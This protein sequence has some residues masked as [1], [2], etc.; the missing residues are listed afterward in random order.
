MP[1][2]QPKTRKLISL[3]FALC[4]LEGLAALLFV[5]QTQSMARNAALFGFSTARL[6]MG[7]VILLVALLFAAAA[8]LI[9]FNQRLA[10]RLDE[11]L[12][13]LFPKRE[14]L[15]SALWT[16]AVLF[17]VL[18]YAV[19]FFSTHLSDH[20][21]TSQ[22]V[23]R[24][25]MPLLYW[26]LL[27]LLQSAVLLYAA[28]RDKLRS[29]EAASGWRVAQPLLVTVM[30]LTTAFYLLD[31]LAHIGISFELGFHYYAFMAVLLL[32]AALTVLQDRY[33]DRDWFD[34]VVFYLGGMLIFCTA[35]FIY[36]STAE[37]VNYMHTPSKAYFPDLANAFLNGRL[38]LENPS[39]TMDLTLYNG[40]WYMAFPPLAAILMLPLVARFGPYG[41]S[42]V[43]F[44]LTFAAVNVALVYLI[45]ES[46]SRLGWS[47]LRTRDNLWLV[48]MFALGTIHWYMA[49]T[50]RVW[51]LSR[52]LTVT[53]AALAVLLALRRRSPFWVGLALAVAMAARPNIAFMGVFLLGIAM[54][55]M[56]EAGNL[57]FKRVVGWSLAAVLPMLA[58]VGGLLY[59]NYLRF[60]DW[61]DFGY[62][63]MNVGVNIPVVQQ[64][65]QFHPS[66]IGF[67][68]RYML[69]KLPYI[70][71]DCYGRPVP[72]PQ[73]IS[74]L[75][76][77]PALIYLLRSFKRSWWVAAAWLAVLLEVGL[78]SM[79]TGY[80]W[81]FGYR[82]IMD[83]MLP[84]LALLAIGAG[85]RVSWLMR[86]L[87]LAGVV[88]N[89]CGVL[90][91]FD[92]WCPV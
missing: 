73:G 15:L 79:H 52:I 31:K 83:F 9:L 85:R 67:N 11:G 75:V 27:V 60:G 48:L 29:T 57:T 46:L 87:I 53:F 72:D 77:T 86:V 22:P 25:L 76:T 5:F 10:A 41:F 38:Y 81:E 61:M 45:L 65:G 35:F 37:F 44:G 69:L 82:F 42:T 62:A 63:T 30:L 32:S 54:Q 39:S 90:W 16:L 80:A 20:L 3:F 47:K 59:Y 36:I 50:G 89:F 56:Q 40:Q 74:I 68:L 91:Y 78:L 64:Y 26:A 17:T 24:R 71:A 88:V 84:M 7:G 51:Y 19:V 13:K 28:F 58:V 49:I 66:F 70:S 55:H 12:Q 1:H 4:A 33:R 6:A 23:F 8:L 21:V 18:A 2:I 14:R 34:K 43:V 92:M